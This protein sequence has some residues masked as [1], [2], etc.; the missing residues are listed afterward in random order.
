MPK[1]KTPRRICLKNYIEKFGLSTDGN[2]LFCKLCEVK[3]K[4][5]KKF[6]V[7]QQKKN[8]EM[9]VK[10]LLSLEKQTDKI[11]TNLMQKNQHF[12]KFVKHWVQIFL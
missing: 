4:A 11:T 10:A 12:T 7:T 3:V 5:E 6:M 2:I 8:W 9:Y 1:D